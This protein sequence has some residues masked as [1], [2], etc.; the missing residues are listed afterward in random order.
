VKNEPKYRVF[1][2]AK[3][4]IPAVPPEKSLELLNYFTENMES[5]SGERPG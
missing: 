3:Q 2:P 1:S 4:Q 5:K